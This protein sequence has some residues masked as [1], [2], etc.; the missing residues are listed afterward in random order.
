VILLALN[1]IK[2]L[3]IILR[4]RG[5]DYLGAV[6][7]FLWHECHYFTL[8]MRMSIFFM[9]KDLTAFEIACTVDFVTEAL[10]K[11]HRNCWKN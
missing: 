3:H 10:W 11:S 1:L 5:A 4:Q 9:K 2:E 8:V 6:F 7:S